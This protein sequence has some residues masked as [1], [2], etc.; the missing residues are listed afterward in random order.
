MR[1]LV[2]LPNSKAG[3]QACRQRKLGTVPPCPRCH[4]ERLV[5]HDGRAFFCTVCAWSWR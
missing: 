2:D 4:E 3:S 5:E 1:T